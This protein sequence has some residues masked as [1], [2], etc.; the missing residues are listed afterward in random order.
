M[1][2]QALG[3]GQTQTLLHGTLDAHQA[4]AK[5]IF[6]HLTDTTDAPIAQVI[7]VVHHTVAVADIDQ[8]LQGINNVFFGQYAVTGDGVA[9]DAPIELHTA[10]RGQI[11]PFAGEK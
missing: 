4:D 7:D 3:F 5:H 6:G 1:R 8:Y 11:V 10:H 9:T 2:H